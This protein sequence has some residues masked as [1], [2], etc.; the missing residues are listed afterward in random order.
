[1]TERR[2]FLVVLAL[3]IVVLWAA[4][5]TLAPFI[6]AAVLAYAFTPLVAVAAA[7]TRWPRAVIVLIGYAAVLGAIG[8]AVVFSSG[9]I[10]TEL[11]ALSAAGPDL[12]ASALRSI[13][14]SNSMTVLGTTLTVADI[15]AALRASIAGAIESP[16]SAIHIAGLVV[17]T[18]LQSILVLIVTFYLIVD[19][20]RIR[21]FALSLIPTAD[22][23]RVAEVLGHVQ[24]TLAKWLRGQLVLIIGVTV[25]VY[26]FLGPIL[27][28]PYAVAI[29]VLTGILEIIPLV[30]PVIAAALAMVAA[31]TSGGTTL[32]I[33]VGVGYVVLRQVEDQLVMPIV[34]GRAVHLHPVV[35]IFAVLAGLSIYGIIGGLLAVPIA[36][37]I[38][39]V[40]TDLYTAPRRAAQPALGD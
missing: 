23:P 6:V 11:Q 32:A 16:G 14:G 22:Q 5:A 34:I 36:A 27:H 4:R 17:D 31:L 40:F 2:A 26:L 30:G 19:G 10:G 28:V 21:D 7:R 12:V 15:A 29:S 13:L 25:V 37:A 20:A 8:V 9:K 38:N 24:D 1:M 33:V 3:L 39:V 18:L 35:T